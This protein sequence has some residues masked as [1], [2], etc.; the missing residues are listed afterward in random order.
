MARVFVRHRLLAALVIC[1][2]GWSLMPFTS[3]ST[4]LF[5]WGEFAGAYDEIFQDAFEEGNTRSWTD[6]VPGEL[7]TF[8]WLDPAAAYAGRFRI[9]LESLERAEAEGLAALIGFADPDQVLFAVA[10]R[11]SGAR[12]EARIGARTTDGG[13]RETRW[14]TVGDGS[15]PLEVE[16]RRAL[17]QTGDGVLYLSAG[18]ELRLWLTGLANAEPALRYTGVRRV[19]GGAVLEPLD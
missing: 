6:A 16:W 11:R 19:E 13:W 17:P 4:N 1:V 10:L 14:Q 2:S 5:G 12:I 9:D 15:R 7:E 3:L 18:G 8:G